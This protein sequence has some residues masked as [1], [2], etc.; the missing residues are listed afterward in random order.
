MSQIPRIEQ[1][2]YLSAAGPS[3][4][5][6]PVD[7]SVGSREVGVWSRRRGRPLHGQKLRVAGAH[8]AL[9]EHVKTVLCLDQS[10]DAM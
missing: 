4:E 7:A 5:L 8:D 3:V 2:A 6:C 9:A 1:P 10:G